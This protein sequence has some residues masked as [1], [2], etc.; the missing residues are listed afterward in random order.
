MLVAAT[1]RRK[2]PFSNTLIDGTGL[3]N[4]VVGTVGAL[5]KL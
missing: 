2:L 1:R 4:G 3:S 5:R